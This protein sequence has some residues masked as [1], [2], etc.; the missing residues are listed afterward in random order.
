MSGN[1]SLISAAQAA[2]AV[3]E[4]VGGKGRQLGQLQRYGLPVPDFFVIPAGWSR[5]RSGGVSPDLQQLLHAEL[6]ARGW[7]GTALAVRSSAVGEDAAAA[8]FA[9]IYRSCLNVVGAQALV[10]AVAEVWASLDTPT[11]TAYRQRL[12]IDGEPAM[13]VVV[14]PLLAAEASGIAFTCDPANGRDDRMVVH[15]HWGLGETLVGGEAAGDEYVFAEDTTDVW[16]LL[17]SRPGSKET[18]SVPAPDGGTQRQPVPL[19]RAQVRVLDDAQAEALAALL[20]DAALAC[21]FVAPFYDLEWVWDGGQFWLTQARPV[22]RRPHHTYPALAAQPAI[23]T[24]GNT[25]EVMPVALQA[26]DWNFSRRGCNDL[27]EQGWKL[28]GYPVLPGV[29]RAGLFDGR[30]YLE[31]SIMQWEAWDCIGLLPERF[32]ALMGGHQSVIATTPPTWRQRL[33]RGGNT[34]RYLRHAPA[35]GRRGDAEVAQALAIA[36]ELRDAPLPDN[37]ADITALLFRVLKPAREFVGM[38]FLQG[39]GGGSLSLLLDTLERAF[40]GESEAIGSALLAGGEPSVTAQQGYALLDLARLAKAV[41][42]GRLPQDAPEFARAFATFLDRYGHRG[43]YETYLRS[44]RWSEQPERLLEQ[45]PALAEVDAVAMRARQQAAADAAWERIRRE[46]PFWYRPLLRAQVKAAN[47]DSNRR[48]AARSAIISLLA[49]SR[50]LWLLIGERLVGEGALDRPDDIFHLLPSE[51]ERYAI[52][53]LPL[54]GL[55]ARLA[56]RR[57]LFA[58]WQATTPHEWLTLAPTGQTAPQPP[59]ETAPIKPAD[60]RRFRGVATGTGVARG[61]VRR[62]RH[63]SEGLALQP[64]EILVAP[65]TDP[66]WT[67]LFLK[68]GGLVVETG[69]YLSH[70]AIVAREFGLPAVV[71]LPG[72]LAALHDGDEVEVDGWKGVVRLY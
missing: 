54:A 24:R 72:I 61:K 44:P 16:R 53:L 23:W 27:L 48:E 6:V 52:G 36:R 56:E 13:A 25:C 42:P 49:A 68:A 69:G 3:T 22:T 8:S 62:L 29:Q 30:L 43:H 39:S 60:G 67:P 34:L 38:F 55:R 51:V 46:L 41:A 28:A 17:E 12:Q 21:D 15:A 7:Q 58:R 59:A 35:M 4:Q 2:S 26:M 47:R 20:R 50:R 45:L 19:A 18:M 57:A 71:N 32:N 65:S 31:A 9:G 37:N 70:G 14:M 1:L 10:G 11:A 5:Q 66:G 64:G 63:P 40:P 33:T